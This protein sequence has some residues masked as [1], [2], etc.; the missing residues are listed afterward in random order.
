MDRVNPLFLSLLF[1]H[2]L[3]DFVLQSNRDIARKEEPFFFGKH[4]ALVTLLS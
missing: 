4:I 3:A 1:A 2:L